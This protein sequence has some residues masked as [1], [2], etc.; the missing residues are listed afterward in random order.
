MRERAAIVAGLTDSTMSRDDAW[1]FLVLG[2]SLERVDMLARLLS[3]AVRSAELDARLGR[4]AALLLGPR[5]VPAHLPPG[6]G[7]DPGRGVPA[8][9]PAV[10]PL[11]VLRPVRPPRPA[12]PSSTPVPVGPA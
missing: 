7:T 11:G 9:R 4:P 6:A 1:R 10:P 5:G 2:R 12:W 3:T 8:P